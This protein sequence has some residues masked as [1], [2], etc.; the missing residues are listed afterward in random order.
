MNKKLMMGRSKKD[1]KKYVK[2]ERRYFVKTQTLREDLEK[3]SKKERRRVKKG[4]KIQ[5]VKFCK[6]ICT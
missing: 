5:K 6:G 4:V 2:T 1:I 3:K